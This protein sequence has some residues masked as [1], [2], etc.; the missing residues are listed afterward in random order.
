MCENATCEKN[1]AHV[2]RFRCEQNNLNRLWKLRGLLYKNNKINNTSVCNSAIF[3]LR[4]CAF[5]FSEYVHFYSPSICIIIV[6][7]KL[8]RQ[9]IWIY[10]NLKKILIILHLSQGH[11]AV[12]L[13]YKFLHPK[14]Y[15][16]S[17]NEM[18]LNIYNHRHEG[19][20]IQ[21]FNHYSGDVIQFVPIVIWPHLFTMAICDTWRPVRT[22]YSMIV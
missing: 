13:V 17:A 2:F 15:S 7:W 12:I 20:T 8:Y 9:F 4:I 1:N 10:I 3:I 22:I 5:L 21:I 14:I 11:I 16:F 19:R 18:L 6:R